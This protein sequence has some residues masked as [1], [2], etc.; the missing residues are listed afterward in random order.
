MKQLKSFR[1]EINSAQKQMKSPN[2]LARTDSQQENGLILGSMGNGNTP[3]PHKFNG[4]MNPLISEFDPMSGQKDHHQR[5]LMDNYLQAQNVATAT[6]HVDLPATRSLRNFI[7]PKNQ[8][9]GL[10]QRSGQKTTQQPQRLQRTPNQ[11]VH[12]NPLQAK[13]SNKLK[14]SESK[15]AIP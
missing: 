8:L 12:S 4:G 5:P 7:S 3:T 14:K 2:G 1:G 11:P 6:Q 10:N 9:G 13:D 15:Q